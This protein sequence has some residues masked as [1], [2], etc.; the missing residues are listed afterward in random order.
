MIAFQL[1]YVIKTKVVWCYLSTGRL[2][3]ELLAAAARAIYKVFAKNLASR[4]LEGHHPATFFFRDQ[5]LY[6]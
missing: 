5:T 6:V 1:T 2:D 4:R 3:G